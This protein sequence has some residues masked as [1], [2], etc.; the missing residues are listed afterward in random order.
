[1]GERVHHYQP[2]VRWTGN[3]GEGTSG[4]RTY[5]RDHVISAPGKPDIAGSSDAQFRGD[6]GRW[7]PEDLLVASA[8]A[9]HMLWYL[10][11]CAVNGVIV[12]DYRDAAEGTMEEDA[13]G[14]GS[15]TRITLRPHV[16]ISAASS[17]ARA[18]E[19][20]HEAHTMCFIANSVK[21]EI[22]VEPTFSEG[23]A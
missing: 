17:E 23:P 15:F 19:L 7:N 22:V 4:Y 20:H 10:H 14:S 2:T 16:V 8:A 9:C 21:C 1:M 18:R 5:E 11:L 6:A 12:Q 3:T 13:S